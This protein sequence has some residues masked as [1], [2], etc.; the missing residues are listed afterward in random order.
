LPHVKT[1][2]ATK[3]FTKAIAPTNSVDEAVADTYC[4][5]RAAH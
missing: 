3:A 2:A 1:I 5:L 4:G